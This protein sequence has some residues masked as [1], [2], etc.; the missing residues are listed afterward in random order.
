MGPEYNKSATPA[1]ALC[2]AK[3]GFR[4]SGKA[5]VALFAG[6]SNNVIQIAI[7]TCFTNSFWSSGAILKSIVAGSHRVVVLLDT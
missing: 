5:N 7:T 6:E 3:A 1:A 4:L 2:L